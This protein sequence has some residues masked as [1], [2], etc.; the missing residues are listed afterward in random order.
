MLKI[1]QFLLAGKHSHYVE[2][3]CSGWKD[4]NNANKRIKGAE[5][6]LKTQRKMFSRTGPKYIHCSGY[7]ILLINYHVRKDTR[8]IARKV[9]LA[10]AKT[11]VKDYTGHYIGVWL[12]Y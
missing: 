4:E 6:C 12:P 9:S 5:I 2:I 10:L 11:N 3:F 7:P 8:T 1:M